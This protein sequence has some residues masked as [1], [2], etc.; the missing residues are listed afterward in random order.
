MPFV[1]NLLLL[2]LEELLEAGL[3]GSV[4]CFGLT[5]GVGPSDRTTVGGCEIT[6]VLCEGCG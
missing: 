3:P 5:E 6:T 2:V 4:G 1:A